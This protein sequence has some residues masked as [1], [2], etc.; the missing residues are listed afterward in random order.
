MSARAKQGEPMFDEIERGFRL[1]QPPPLSWIRRLRHLGA[2]AD[3]LAHPEMPAIGG[4][5]FDGG[6][7]DFEN[8]GQP[9]LLFIARDELGI[10]VD[11]VAWHPRTQ[12]IARWL[13]A[14]ALLGEDQVNGARLDQERALPVHETPIDW[15]V[16]G[17]SGV[18]IV[19]PRRAAFILRRAEPLRVANAAF[20]KRL[21]TLLHIAPPR[22][23]APSV[24][25]LKAA[26][27]AV[28]IHNLLST[29]AEKHSNAEA[30]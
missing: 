3:A 21:A 24:A 23:F 12:R 5:S 27:H 20:G 4:V 11:I 26:R 2:T 18:V 28:E 1:L 6:Y 30:A 8:E 9:A 10:P 25:A 15:L 29:G 17:R 7:F 13:G 19:D 22:I 14:V 16:A